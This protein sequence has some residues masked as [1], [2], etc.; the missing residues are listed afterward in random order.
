MLGPIKELR[1]RV[2][3]RDEI[4]ML[5]FSNRRGAPV[6]VNNFLYLGAKALD[7]NGN[8]EWVDAKWSV[9]NGDL[10]LITPRL[11][12]QVRVVGLR[13]TDDPIPIVAEYG[14]HMAKAFIERIGMR[15]DIFGNSGA[16]REQPLRK[17]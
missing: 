14:G 17:R 3:E 4:G 10:V 13:Q 9:D 6:N 11:S 12:S 8:E 2:L 1:V 15:T 16:L 7:A 5:S